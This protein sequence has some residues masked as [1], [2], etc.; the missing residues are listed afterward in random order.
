M[1]CFSRAGTLSRVLAAFC[2]NAHVAGYGVLGRRLPLSFGLKALPPHSSVCIC[3]CLAFR[4]AIQTARLLTLLSLALVIT[5]ST[6]QAALANQP[7]LSSDDPYF[8]SVEACRQLGVILFDQGDEFR[9]DQSMN[10]YQVAHATVI[11]LEALGVEVPKNPDKVRY[12]DIPS[13][14]WAMGDVAGCINLGLMGG[15][16]D[17]SFQGRSNMLKEHWLAMASNFALKFAPAPAPEQAQIPPQFRDLPT[18]NWL[19]TPINTLAKYCWLDPDVMADD[20]L[21]RNDTV[22]RK[23]MY[24]YLGKLIL[25]RKGPLGTWSDAAHVSSAAQAAIPEEG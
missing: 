25:S 10:R 8:E 15:F 18:I 5:V 1:R 11:T 21:N 3:A 20:F 7:T 13:G 24:W 9:F 23:T 22:T 2:Y 14:H 16:E 12:A 19:W 17:L 4:Q 6:A